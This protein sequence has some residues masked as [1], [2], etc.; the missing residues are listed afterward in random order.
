MYNF[1]ATKK[2][3]KNIL[4]PLHKMEAFSNGV[5]ICNYP[6]NYAGRLLILKVI[7]VL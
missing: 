4:V 5:P 6:L 2:E 7:S 3:S 1:S